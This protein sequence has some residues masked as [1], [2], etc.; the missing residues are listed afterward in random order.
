L[1]VFILVHGGWHGGWCWE[2]VT[3][4]LEHAGH[5]ALAPDLPGHGADRTPLSD[6]PWEWYVPAIAE[7][8]AAQS[9]PVILVGHS[10]GGMVI[11]ETARL[12]P[13]SIA[14]LVYLTAFLLPSGATP[15]DVMGD[16]SG[17]LL[18]EAMVVDPIAGLTTIRPEM[19]REV[20]YHD[21]SDAD[22]AWARERL[23]PEPLIPPGSADAANSIAAVEPQVP[24]V[25]I[26][27]LQD[28]ALPL[29]VQRRMSTNL[30]CDS[31]FALETSHSPFLSKPEQLAAILATIAELG[32]GDGGA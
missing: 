11:S 4:L 15:R 17:S 29:A 6:R 23:Q 13:G 22:V 30:P 19:A 5:R 9:E 32:R 21:C 2:R 28:R 8:A 31:V 1:A 18:P 20:F 7:L 24:R 3:P 10:S 16:G 27:T 14:A 26:E 12:Q 25:Y